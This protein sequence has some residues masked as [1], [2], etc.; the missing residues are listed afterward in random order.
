LI[1]LRFRAAAC[2]RRGGGPAYAFPEAV[3]DD[4]TRSDGADHPGWGRD[5]RTLGQQRALLEEPYLVLYETQPDTDEGQVEAVA[6]V[7]V[8]D[9][10]R[11]LTA[12]F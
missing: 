5:A 3:A 7:R 8:V 1:A 12:L 9:G 2:L 6:I 11:D 4:G 10:R